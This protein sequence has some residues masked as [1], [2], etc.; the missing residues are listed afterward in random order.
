M[1][2]KA[3]VLALV[4]FFVTAAVCG[5]VAALPECAPYREWQLW[6]WDTAALNLFNVLR[7][8]VSWGRSP[9]SL[10]DVGAF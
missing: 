10:P 1:K 5:P 7:K 9:R 8:F 4:L 6:G 2:P 3:I